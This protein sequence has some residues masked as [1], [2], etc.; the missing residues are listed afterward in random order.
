ML[1]LKARIRRIINDPT[2][3]TLQKRHY[4]ALEAESCLDYPVVPDDVQEALD[5]RVICDMFEGHAPF[6]PR[7]VLPDYR[8][9]LQ[10]GSAH[11]ELAPPEDFDEAL[12]FLKIL[13]HHVPS[14]TGMPVFLGHLDQLLLPFAGALTQ[15]RLVRK[16]RLFWQYLDRT[17]PDAF[18]HAN[19][20][21]SDN[22]IARAILKVDADL[23]QVAPNLT[24][25]HDE[26][27]D[28][29]SLLEMAVD[30]ICAISKP[31][32]ANH[33][34]HAKAFDE[35]GYGIVSCYN[36]LP[37]GG[38]AST[39]M[40]INLKAVAERSRSIDDFF[41]QVLPRYMH[42]GFLLIRARHDYLVK[43]SNFFSGFLT[44]EGL[45]EADRFTA[46]FGIYAMAEC[47][48]CLML[49]AGQNGR[50]GHD[51][52]ANQL[53]YRISAMLAEVV[54]ETPMDGL[55]RGRAMLH[56]QAGISE[57]IGATPGVRIPYGT[58]PD[59]VEHITALAP[60]HRH[61]P[62]GVSEILTLD[63]TVKGNPSAIVQLCKGAFALGFREFSANVSGNDLVRVTGYMVRLSDIEKFIGQQGSRINTT[64]LGAEAAEHTGILKRCARV[65][66]HEQNPR[67][68]Q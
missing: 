38:G 19:I 11:L 34:I 42:L 12:N 18:M 58:E 44:R 3:N 13:Y 57:D 56:A 31:H 2:L 66:S 47:V 45:I 50:Y 30:N 63:E 59:L 67:Y 28:T 61:Y 33:S 6:K 41:Q 14:V 37:I 27:L 62:S 23:G 10:Q 32:I 52:S 46:M 4:L 40:R 8:K 60:H 16:L 54:E 55:W 35:R 29:E 24:Y 68:R 36:V 48:N 1:E 64:V 39:L 51:E 43:E 20:G 17:L 9:A 53:G 25:L 26:T 15:E 65:I 49:K 5:D 22:P 7:Y 21:P